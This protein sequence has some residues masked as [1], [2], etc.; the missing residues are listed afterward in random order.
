[1]FYFAL[2]FYLKGH[3]TTESAQYIGVVF[4]DRIHREYSYKEELKLVNLDQDKRVSGGL[5]MQ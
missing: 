2:G 4:K 5:C 3:T 1:V